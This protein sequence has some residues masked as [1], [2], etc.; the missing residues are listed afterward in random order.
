MAVGFRRSI[1]EVEN[2]AP[3]LTRG[4]NDIYSY[5]DLDS[6]KAVH[7]VIDMAVPILPRRHFVILRLFLPTA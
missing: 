1:L 7:H 3:G 2:Y 4:R 6:R 5:D